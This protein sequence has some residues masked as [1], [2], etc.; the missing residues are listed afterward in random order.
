M[1]TIVLKHGKAI[2]WLKQEAS[3]L[4]DNYTDGDYDAS[5]TA[6]IIKELLEYIDLIQKKDWE[7]V[8]IEECAM[9]VSNINVVEMTRKGDIDK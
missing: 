9:A 1:D 6:D 3:Y 7:W 8:A 5:E 4:I 2:A